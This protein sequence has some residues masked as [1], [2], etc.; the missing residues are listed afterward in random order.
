MEQNEGFGIPE[1]AAIPVVDETPEQRMSRLQALA[2]LQIGKESDAEIIERLVAEARARRAAELLPMDTAGFP[3]VY[4]RIEIY[5]GQGEHDLAYV[6]LSI[7][8]FCIK[9]P[10]GVEIILPH[11]FV[12][13]VLDQAIETRVT[14]RVGGLVLRSSHRFPYRVIGSATPDEYRA[15]Q[16]EQ[17]N[18]VATQ[19]AAAA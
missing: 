8:G 15:Y 13:D 10:R 4:D 14:Q 1:V 19:L 2:D 7:N 16:I 3:A 12:T 18:L 5:E 9:A 11:I 17:K 6:P